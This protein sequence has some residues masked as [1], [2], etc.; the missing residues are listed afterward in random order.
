VLI[1]EVK[2]FPG[3]VSQRIAAQSY[4]PIRLRARRQRRK[5]AIENEKILGEE[6]ENARILGRVVAN[7]VR[8][9]DAPAGNSSLLTKV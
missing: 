1:G 3:E 7:N 6:V 8:L 2:E 5:P 9:D 4:R